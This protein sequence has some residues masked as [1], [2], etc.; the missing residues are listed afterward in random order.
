[1]YKERVGDDSAAAAALEPPPRPA[2]AADKLSQSRRLCLRQ[3]WRRINPFSPYAPHYYKR[4]KKI[5]FLSKEVSRIKKK[6]L[7]KTKEFSNEAI[8]VF[9]VNFC[10]LLTQFIALT[11]GKGGFVVSFRSP[12]EKLTSSRSV[13]C[14]LSFLR[15]RS[16]LQNFIGNKF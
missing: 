1:M 12:A 14:C 16:H 13:G 6:L 9:I 5:F 3:Q 15:L 11:S 4:R 7:K 10:R 8:L 2:A